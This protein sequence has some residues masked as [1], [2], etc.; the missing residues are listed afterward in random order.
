MFYTPEGMQEMMRIAGFTGL[1]VVT[2][3][4]DFVY[5]S[6]EEYWTAQWSHG[7]RGAL[8]E[9]ERRHGAEGLVRFQAEFF[10]K[11]AAFQQ[12]DGLHEPSAVLYTIAIKP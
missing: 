6:Q 7:M 4:A 1:Q 2:E 8:E 10:S 5:A 9:I 12:P 3:T 11:L